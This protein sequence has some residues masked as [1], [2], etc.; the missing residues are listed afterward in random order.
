[1]LCIVFF[2]EMI[3]DILIASFDVNLWDFLEK[4]VLFV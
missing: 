4:Y 3:V 2:S 1:M